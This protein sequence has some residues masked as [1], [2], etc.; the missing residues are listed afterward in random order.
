ML[1]TLEETDVVDLQFASRIRRKALR[2][3]SEGFSRWPYSGS[4]RHAEID[5]IAPSTCSV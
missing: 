5:D 4:C 1:S 3:A 2:D